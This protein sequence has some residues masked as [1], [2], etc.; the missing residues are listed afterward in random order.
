MASALDV[1]KA[2][3]PPR[4]AFLDF[5]LGHTTGKPN[6]PELQ[7]KILLQ[8]LESFS[9]ITEPGGVLTLDFRWSESDDWKKN[10]ILERKPRLDT[11]QYQTEEDRTRAER[12]F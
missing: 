5:P 7:R 8:A 2:V 1:I 3:N 4:T 10:I 6:D 9:R 11:P 12:Q